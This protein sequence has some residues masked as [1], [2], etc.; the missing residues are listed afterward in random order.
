MAHTIIALYYFFMHLTISGSLSM[1]FKSKPMHRQKRLHS[2]FS[3]RTLHR[4]DNTGNEV[5]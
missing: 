1:V 2:I 3:L 5:S 4:M